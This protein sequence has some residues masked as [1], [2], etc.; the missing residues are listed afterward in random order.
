MERNAAQADLTHVTARG[1][2]YVPGARSPEELETLLE[3]AFVTRDC[4]ALVA[5]FADG[6]L[7][8]AGDRPP[9]RGAEIPRVASALWESGRTYIADP[10]RVV[11]THDS[12]LV[13]ADGAI[14]VMRRGSD[15]AWRYVI[16]LLSFDMHP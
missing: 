12:A 14:N 5:L 9:A 6:G 10:R 7:F 4:M 8:A 13:V 3:D 16:S 1:G 2:A 11:Q 15:G